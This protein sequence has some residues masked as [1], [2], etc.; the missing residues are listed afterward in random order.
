MKTAKLNRTV[1]GADF[2][3][4]KGTLVEI[5]QNNTN[6]CMVRKSGEP[7]LEYKVSKDALDIVPKIKKVSLKKLE[8]KFNEFIYKLPTEKTDLV[9]KDEGDMTTII[10]ISDK[11]QI[12]LKCDPVYTELKDRVYGDNVLKIDIVNESVRNMVVWAVSHD[13]TISEN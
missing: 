6:T 10:F 3:L 7:N 5:A 11:A 2:C 12:A 13:L 4:L 8:K 9:F 1:K